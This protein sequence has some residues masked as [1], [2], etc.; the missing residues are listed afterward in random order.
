M[1]GNT[2]LPKILL[3]PPYNKWY[4]EAHCE[5]LIRYL[6]D[7]FFIEIASP[8]YDEPRNPLMRDPDDYDLVWPLW[9][10]AWR[11][12]HDKYA[13]KVATVFYCPNEGQYKETAVVGASTPMVEEACKR[14][15]IPYHSLRFGVDTNL[16]APYEM[17]REDDLLHV[18]YIGNH[19][20]VR[21]M[22]GPVISKLTDIKGVRIMLFPHNW[23]N[24]G[25]TATDWDGEK[26]R[27]Y[28]VGGDKLWTGI[29]NIYN[30]M[31]VLLRMD[32]DPAYS[33]PTQEA[34]ACGVPTIVTNT[35]IDHLF[36]DAGA[37]I[38]IPGDRPYYMT[39]H[40]E[41]AE[42]VRE[43]II[44][45]R[46]HPKKRKEMGK[47]GREEVLKNWTWDKHIDNW[48]QFFREGVKNARRT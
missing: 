18:G 15:H 22:V 14:D 40:G 10:G 44:D 39:H 2:K 36:S 27:S 11:I 25:G 1:T 46:D 30:R 3:I 47:K 4:V 20:N 29:P 19:A 23:V 13:H 33:F 37:G 45:L 42:K 6:S 12:E 41:V 5:Y 16:F 28:V 21:H 48:R 7:E 8:P 26:M 9:P 32:E 17:K 43:A 38:M 31:D 34:A 35:G 24:D